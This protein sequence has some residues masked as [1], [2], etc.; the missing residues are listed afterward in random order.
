W[1][2][3]LPALA[4][5]ETGEMTIAGKNT[6]T[7]RN[8]VAGEVWVASGQS[9]MEF[10]ESQTRDAAEETKAANFPMIRMFTV[11]KNPQLEPVEDVTGKWELCTPETV[12]GFSAVGYFF[13]RHV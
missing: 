8:V 3:M 4:A 1:K 6:L 5:G 9:N 13:A 7:L 10:R 2:V 11:Q 12:P